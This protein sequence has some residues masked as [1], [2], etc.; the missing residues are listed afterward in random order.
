MLVEPHLLLLLLLLVLIE[1]LPQ[2]VELLPLLH[3]LLMLP[4][5]LFPMPVDLVLLVIFFLLSFTNLLAQLVDLLL[6]ARHRGAGGQCKK[7]GV[8]AGG[9]ALDSAKRSWCRKS[10]ELL[11]PKWRRTKQRFLSTKTRHETQSKK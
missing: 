2:P 10:A 4:I 5:E 3:L 1:L 6:Q 8:G 11:E 9:G 7:R